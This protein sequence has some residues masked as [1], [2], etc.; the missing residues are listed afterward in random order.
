MVDYCKGRYKDFCECALEPEH[1][2]DCR[3]CIC[4][5][6]GGCIVID[7][8]PEQYSTQAAG[9]RCEKP[10][11]IREWAHHGGCLN[12][13]KLKGLEAMSIDE[14]RNTIKEIVIRATGALR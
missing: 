4:T 10:E 3:A 11:C 9:G 13:E 12:R 6:S 8:K 7:F 14:A 2:G 5:P 1:E